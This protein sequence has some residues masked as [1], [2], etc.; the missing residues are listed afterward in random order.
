MIPLVAQSGGSQVP[1]PN[2]QRAVV[3]HVLFVLGVG[4][5]PFIVPLRCKGQNLVP[6]PSFELYDTCPQQPGFLPGGRP[7]AWWAWDQSPE[8]FN[9]CAGTLGGVDTLLDVPL[10]GF[11]W[12]NAYD[13]GAYV[14]GAAFETE[15]RELVGAELVDPLV[16]GQTYYVSFRTNLAM[17][18]TY[19]QTGLACN[20]IGLLFTME[21][22]SWS[23]NTGTYPEFAH[24]NYAHVHEPSIITDTT[25]WT[26]VSGT[27]VADSAYRYVVLGNLFSDSL[28]DTVTLEPGLL[29]AAYYLYDAVCV[30]A[31]P[32][33]CPLTDQSAGPPLIFPNPAADHFTVT[34]SGLGEVRI[35]DTAGRLVLLQQC[36]AD[37]WLDVR[38]LAAGTYLLSVERQ[39]LGWHHSK[40]VV[41]H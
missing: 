20:N 35:V 14:G 23:G 30:S 22:H 26:L 16:V 17:N 8:Y 34:G 3:W 7:L 1:I 19:W 27:F 39:G 37:C 15:L 36:S 29:L 5:L 41:V 25:G 13:G 12:Q 18:G 32:A 21:P 9:A 6:N 28:T 11:T 40:L 31:Q 10:N 2:G 24:R 38:A 4:Y 33:E